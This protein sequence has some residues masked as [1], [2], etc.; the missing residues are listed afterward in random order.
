MW[1]GSD[2]ESLERSL[3]IARKLESWKSSMLEKATRWLGKFREE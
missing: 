2:I 1:S 3:S